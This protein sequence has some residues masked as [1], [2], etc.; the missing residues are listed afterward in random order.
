MDERKFLN[1]PTLKEAQFFNLDE[2]V[3]DSNRFEE[4]ECK[5]GQMR[6]D[7]AGACAKLALETNSLEDRDTKPTGRSACISETSGCNFGD[8]IRKSSSDSCTKLAFDPNLYSF[9]DND[10]TSSFRSSRAY[11]VFGENGCDDIRE[12]SSGLCS[13]IIL[14]SDSFT[15]GDGDSS[16]FQT[17][18]TT[19][20]TN[21]SSYSSPG[22]F[23]F[24]TGDTTC[25]DSV[26]EYGRNEDEE[27]QSEKENKHSYPRQQKR[28]HKT[29]NTS[30]RMTIENI[31]HSGDHELKEV[32]IMPIRTKSRAQFIVKGAPKIPYSVAGI[33]TKKG[34]SR[35]KSKPKHRV[36]VNSGRMFHRIKPKPVLTNASKT[37]LSR[38]NN[39]GK[40]KP[41]T[42]TRT[43]KT[44]KGQSS[45]E[46]IVVYSEQD[47]VS[48]LTT[49]A[50]TPVSPQNKTKL[51]LNSND[52]KF[53]IVNGNDGNKMINE[54]G[55]KKGGVREDKA[56][57]KKKWRKEAPQ[58]S[59]IPR[60]YIDSVEIQYT[61]SSQ[62]L[63][64]K[65]SFWNRKS[66][67]PD[68]APSFNVTIEKTEIVQ[69]TSD[70]ALTNEEIDSIVEDEE[71]Q[72]KKKGK[73]LGL[74]GS[75]GKN[76]LSPTSSRKKS[77]QEGVALGEEDMKEVVVNK[78]GSVT[79]YKVSYKMGDDDLSRELKVSK[80]DES[81]VPCDDST[82]IL[83]R[84][85]VSFF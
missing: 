66:P 57:K 69:M 79:N 50:F 16:T 35:D 32:T 18:S 20:R 21:R 60:E 4:I 49:P 30:N 55:H 58:P 85:Q 42:K 83:V 52:T 77:K 46:L 67:L 64:R 36:K 62:S 82:D 71:F 11:S 2:E 6:D 56:K 72:T 8:G 27:T 34:L 84:I 70:E 26:T 24:L 38:S 61:N 78:D 81:L 45:S 39:V 3:I 19:S 53:C 43:R 75:I 25:N 80:V 12:D 48:L 23:S 33:C 40:K 1:S 14:H 31:L 28:L 74:I 44:N 9:G 5:L 65:Q 63:P 17:L 59:P 13:N 15:Y 37:S 41:T 47:D 7:S 10:T 54:D 29:T 51:K 76:P 73:V 22:I 68:S